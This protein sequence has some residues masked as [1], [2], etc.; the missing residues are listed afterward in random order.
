[1]AVAVVQHVQA[2]GPMGTAPVPVD[3]CEPFEGGPALVGQGR[4]HGQQ[5]LGAQALALSLGR[6]VLS[7][8][9][10]F[11]AHDSIPSTAWRKHST[12]VASFWPPGRARM[13][14]ESGRIL[15]VRR[16]SRSS[17]A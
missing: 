17:T 6:S 10:G 13:T 4:L 8:V 12:V 5:A 16:A 3:Q 1:M 15:P 7:R 14:V 11:A 9:P 2:V